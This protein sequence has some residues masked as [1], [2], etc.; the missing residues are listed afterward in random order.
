[1]NYELGVGKRGF[2]AISRKS[3]PNY[4]IFVWGMV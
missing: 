1:M 2:T 3:T 4:C